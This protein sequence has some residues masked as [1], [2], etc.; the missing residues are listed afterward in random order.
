MPVAETGSVSERLRFVSTGLQSGACWTHDREH[1]RGLKPADH[2]RTTLRAQS[3]ETLGFLEKPVASPPALE[4]HR[5]VSPALRAPGNDRSRTY[6]RSPLPTLYSLSAATL[7]YRG[8]CDPYNG[9]GIKISMTESQ[10][11]SQAQ[12]SLPIISRIRWPERTAATLG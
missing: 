12:L 7:A 8:R 4:G 11:T 2:R 3:P 10:G 9:E 1:C 6:Q 5:P